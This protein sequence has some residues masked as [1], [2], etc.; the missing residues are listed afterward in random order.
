MSK[1][2]M[3]I[4]LHGYNAN[5][6]AMKILDSTFRKIAPKNSL[7][8]YPDAP[9]KVNG[10]EGYCWFQFVFGDDPFSINEEYIFHSMNLSMPYIKKYVAKQLELNSSFDYN[11]IIFVGFSQGAGLSLHSSIFLEKPVCGAISFSGGLANPHNEISSEKANKSPILLIH[12]NKDQILP[13]Q[14]SQRGYKMLKRANFDVEYH[15]LKDTEHIITPEAIKIA[16]KF[17]ERI[18]K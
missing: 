17:I 4:F 18:C 10:G 5:G 12:G 7:F 11:D 8:L 2:K 13:Y 15:L 1:P 9:F 14:F 6:E 16:G 3:F